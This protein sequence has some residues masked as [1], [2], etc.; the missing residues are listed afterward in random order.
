MAETTYKVSARKSCG[1][2]VRVFARDHS[3]II[4]EP[5]E[6]GGTDA[7]MN[8]VELMLCSVASCM[9]LTLSIYAEAMGVKAEDIRIDAEGDLDSAGMKGSS[10]VRPG[11][12]RIRL[13][14]SAKTNVAPEVFQ[15]VVDLAVLRCPVEDSIKNSVVFEEPEVSIET[16]QENA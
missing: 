13:S 9:A 7:G 15:Q 10:R 11:F 4:D 6:K 3:I 12:N 2:F 8:P 5:V 14:I 16:I 1:E